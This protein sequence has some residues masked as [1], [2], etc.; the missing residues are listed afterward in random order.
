MTYRQWLDTLY[1]RLPRFEAVCLIEQFAVLPGD[2]LADSGL[3]DA[4]LKG[5][6]LLRGGRRMS[7]DGSKLPHGQLPRFYDE[8]AYVPGLAEAFE[9]RVAGEPLQYILGEW[10]FLSL[11]LAVGPGVLIPRQDTETLCTAVSEMW[12]GSAKALDLCA[13][14]GC[15]ALG[16]CSLMGDVTVTAVE[17][18]EAAFEYLLENCA[19]YPQYRVTSVRADVLEDAASFEPVDIITCNPPYIPR[20]E[21]PLLQREVQWEP[22]AALDGGEDGLSFYRALARD[23]MCKAKLLVVE[24]GDGQAAAVAEIFGKTGGKL[25]I[26]RDAAGMERVVVAD[27][28]R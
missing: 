12:H 21:L 13:G 6:G 22:R 5:D 2:S 14:T 18:D 9:R 20:G 26:V 8:E 4:A 23:W 17:K 28:R 7:H 25:R 10:D 15:V 24:V 3:T 19:R 16:L 1:A 27:F 11:T